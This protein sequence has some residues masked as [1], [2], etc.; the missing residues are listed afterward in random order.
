MLH[1]NSSDSFIPACDGNN[2]QNKFATIKVF[3][4]TFEFFVCE[5]I[6]SS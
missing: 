4:L 5:Q 3:S 6:E 1:I 2:W